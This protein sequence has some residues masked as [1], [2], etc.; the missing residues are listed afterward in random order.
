[1]YKIDYNIISHKILD[2]YYLKV[3]HNVIYY[4]DNFLNSKK[5]M[6]K[7]FEVKASKQSTIDYLTKLRD[8]DSY[9]KTLILGKIPDL[10]NIISLMPKEVFEKSREYKE[11]KKKEKKDRA[12]IDD[13]NLILY[14]IFVK[15]C[16]E[17]DIK[18]NA[19]KGNDRILF[20]SGD[21]IDKKKHVDNFNLRTCP[22][23]NRNYIFSVKIKRRKKNL[24]IFDTTLK[25]QIDHFF[26]KSIFPFL[27]A[28]F[29]NL[30]PTCGFCNG[31][32]VKGEIPPIKD[33]SDPEGSEII[34]N[35]YE[36]S[37]DKIKFK[38]K[39]ND[40]NLLRIK[41]SD[42]ELKILGEQRYIDGYQYVFGLNTLLNGHKDLI[43]D[44]IF[45]YAIKYPRSFQES[46]E[47]ALGGISIND[48]LL[49]RTFWGF[50]TSKENYH[51]RSLSKFMNDI[52]IAI[53]DDTEL[54][55]K[56]KNDLGIDV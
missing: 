48:R 13:L 55:L 32:D 30:I 38:Y 6:S 53:K 20:S 17:N 41:E 56:I 10:R 44:L 51:Q 29:F 35:P 46:V 31:L 39:L 16:Y 1:M 3:S 23:C 33:F 52:Y 27:G 37:D 12:P 18:Q 34:M 45:R 2:E 11:E 4:A 8:D 22:Y 15:G 47:K 21:C 40:V 7:D 24:Q 25:P 19:Y 5:Y 49:N 42:V 28:S 36:Y 9:L 43:I 54:K 50:E 14:Y 26:P